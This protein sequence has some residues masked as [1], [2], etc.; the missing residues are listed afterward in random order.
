M[1]RVICLHGPE[2]TG[3][4]TLA[5]RIAAALGG[6]IV[7]EFGRTYAEARGTEFAM[8]DLVEIART[9][10]QMTRVA[11]QRGV[12]PVI[13]DTDPLMTAAWAVMLHGR[14]D[15]WFDEWHGL[16][17]LY[18]MFDADI[19]WVDDGTRM[20]GTADLRRRFLDVSR[21]ELERRGARWAWVRGDGDARFESAMAAIRAA[22][23]A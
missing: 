5:P 3:K 22:G 13:L 14:R 4:S 15:P 7:S 16:A 12:D 17:D 23:L 6:G 8:A 2:S 20:F 19:A 10:D 21:E 18:L 1:S 9:H 11:I